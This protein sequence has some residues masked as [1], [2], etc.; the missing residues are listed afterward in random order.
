MPSDQ[1]RLNQVMRHIDRIKEGAYPAVIGRDDQYRIT[2]RPWAE[3]P[4]RS[5]LAILQDAV[6]WSG[7]TNRDQGHILLGEI[8]PGKITDAQRNGLIEMASAPQ[9]YDEL[10]EEKSA[11][12]GGRAAA[13][14]ADVVA[15][16]VVGETHPILH[17]RA[18]ETAT[19][20]NRV[21]LHI[22][23]SVH[24]L[25]VGVQDLGLLRQR[26][27]LERGGQVVHRV[28]HLART[29]AEHARERD[30]QAGD[31]DA[32]DGGDGDHDPQVGGHASGGQA[33]AARLG[34]AARIR[35]SYYPNLFLARDN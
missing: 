21:Q 17:R 1:K 12:V 7:I 11:G 22:G 31:H 18:H 8:D 33:V 35:E 34:H 29:D 30:G 13:H 14:R 15:H 9:S 3:M 32:H 16:A 10:L 2:E 19:F 25:A 28:G 20:R 23:V 5:K 6:D 26:V 27:G 24:D 4:E